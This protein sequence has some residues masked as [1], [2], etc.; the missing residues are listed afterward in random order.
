MLPVISAGAGTVTIH[1]A[2]STQGT[3]QTYDL[4]ISAN[5]LASTTPGGSDQ[6]IVR[7]VCV[8]VLN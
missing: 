6:G 3:P 4:D 1:V 8:D 2:D 7:R 5:L